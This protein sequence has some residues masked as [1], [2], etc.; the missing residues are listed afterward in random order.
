[1]RSGAIMAR[2]EGGY[3]G[4]RYHDMLDKL[5]EKE[6]EFRARALKTVKITGPVPPPPAYYYSPEALRRYELRTRTRRL[7]NG[8]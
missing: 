6:A 5:E 3:E 1:M 8:D 4:M 2:V 7:I